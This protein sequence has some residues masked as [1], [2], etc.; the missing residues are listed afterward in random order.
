MKTSTTVLLRIKF[1]I[2]QIQILTFSTVYSISWTFSINFN[3]IFVNRAQRDKHLITTLATNHKSMQ[4]ND[5]GTFR[6]NRSLKRAPTMLGH[7]HTCVDEQL[8]QASDFRLFSWKKVSQK[9]YCDV[10]LHNTGVDKP[11]KQASKAILTSFRENRS[12]QRVLRC[13][14]T[15][16]GGWIVSENSVGCLNRRLLC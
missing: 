9:S 8:Q 13:W 10:G 5:L 4:A 12:L 11:L 16:T 14:A 2:Y 3:V 1:V 7:I 6:G 15:C